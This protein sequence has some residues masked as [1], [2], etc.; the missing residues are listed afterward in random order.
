MPMDRYNEEDVRIGSA[1]GG[2][3]KKAGKVSLKPKDWFPKLRE[4]ALGAPKLQKEMLKSDIERMRSGELGLT[5]AEKRQRVADTM[6][7][8]NA[9]QQAQ[10]SQLGRDALAGQDFQQ[11]AFVEAA[12]EVADAGAQAAAS[13]SRAAQDASDTLAEREATR[14]RSELAAA[15]DRKRETDQWW[16]DRG[17]QAGA[18]LSGNP[19]LAKLFSS[20]RE[21]EGE[22]D[23]E[24]ENPTVDPNEAFGTGGTEAG[25][26]SG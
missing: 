13:A 6:T 3:R 11:G 16:L 14:I 24:S 20:K 25:Q 5:E 19:E 7:Q 23:G 9:Q 1:Q 18:I 22:G 12:G 21:G 10:Q 17:I 4:K 8:V 2:D 15:A 26:V